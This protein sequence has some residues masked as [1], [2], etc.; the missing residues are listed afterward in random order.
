MF[1]KFFKAAT[2][3]AMAAM[4]AVSA[5]SVNAATTPAGYDKD[6]KVNFSVTCDKKGYEFNVY[7]IADLSKGTTTIKYTSAITGGTT[8]LQISARV[9]IQ[10]SIQA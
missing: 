3:V 4:C 5:V 8:R 6:H 9:P 10:S 2:A 7:K 1:K